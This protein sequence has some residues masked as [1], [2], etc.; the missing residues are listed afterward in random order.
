MDNKKNSVFF[1][2]LSFFFYTHARDMFSSIQGICDSHA[3]K[4]AIPSERF[5]V[6]FFC[7]RHDWCQKHKC[8]HV[9]TFFFS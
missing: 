1:F 3:Y 9:E 8:I 6:F 4:T 2:F 5:C 7:F